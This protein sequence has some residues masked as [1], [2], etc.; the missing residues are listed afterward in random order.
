[1]ASKVK[2]AL[3]LA[4]EIPGLEVLIFSAEEPGI[5]E[6]V[7]QGGQTGTLLHAGNLI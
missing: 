3:D 7:L 6:K 4:A 2:G 1:M 5:L